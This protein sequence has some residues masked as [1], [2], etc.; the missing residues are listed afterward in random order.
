MKLTMI[1]TGYVGLVSGVC[2]SEYGFEVTCVD[3]DAA[4]IAR[5][6]RGEVPIYEAGLDELMARN[7]AA[8]RLRF[9]GDL[10]SAV[11]ESDVVMLAV[12]T[13][14]RRGDG[15]AD[16]TFVYAAAK[17]IAPHL[18]PGAV[19][20]TKSTVLPGTNRQVR[21]IIAEERP[22]LDFSV[23]SNP[24][25]LREGAAVDD[26]MRPNR[27]VIGVH[28]ERGERVMRALYRPLSLREAPLVVTTLENAELIKY[29]ANSFLSMKVTFINEVADLCEQI[30]GDV[31]VV[32]HAIGLDH[33]IG[34]KFL[35]PGPGFGGSCFPKDTR[36]FVAAGQ[37]LGA[38]Q[39]L[40]ETVVEVNELR[41]EKMAQKVLAALG[42]PEGK[43]V[44]VLGLAFKPNTDD[45]R[46]APSLTIIP[47][48]QGAGVTIRAHDPA[49]M[50][51]AKTLFDRVEWCEN[52]YESALDAD[53]V[54]IL[55]EW[56][57]YRALDLERLKAA[58][59]GRT[60]ID[61][62]NIYKPQDMAAAGFDYTS[63]GRASSR[64][65]EASFTRVKGQAS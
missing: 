43:I 46:E 20:V 3:A 65:A 1:G 47:A 44:A 16:L 53:A 62:R 37:R 14:S 59:A 28:D 26:F 15:E 17:Q 24:E 51:R 4:K 54:L 56:N 45:M 58:M 38:R 40:I 22:G 36:A 29:A 61:L 50:E 34:Q 12:G 9:T 33:R 63:V 25:F 8:D 64:I 23:A 60:V 5:L 41:A 48:L 42:E 18:K 30:G 35:H 31:Q 27:V 11:A 49:A 32:A 52:P 21:R 19:V 6:N 57:A 13:P 10:A 7:V 39:R 2:F 55:T